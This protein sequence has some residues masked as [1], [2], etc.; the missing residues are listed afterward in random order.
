MGD[1]Y[2]DRVRRETAHAPVAP[3]RSEGR[4]EVEQHLK[5]EEIEP[6]LVA[7][8]TNAGKNDQFH[9]TRAAEGEVLPPE[10]SRNAAGF[11]LSN[12]VVEV[13]VKQGAIRQAMANLQSHSA[14]AYF[15]GGT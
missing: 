3:T 7:A 6:E 9:P 13:Q 4:W 14:I 8:F 1:S 12:T 11:L 10:F 15:A 2:A 5:N